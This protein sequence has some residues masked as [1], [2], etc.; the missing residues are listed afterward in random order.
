MYARLIKDRSI[1]IYD[2]GVLIKGNPFKTQSSAASAIG[3][4]KNTS[5]IKRYI[6]TGKIYLNRYTI[7]S[8]KTKLI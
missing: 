4:A 8:K 5:I 3:L 1:W 7:Y 6:D 2:N